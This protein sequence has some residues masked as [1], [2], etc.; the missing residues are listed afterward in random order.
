MSETETHERV[1]LYEDKNYFSNSAY[2]QSDLKTA[3]ESPWLMWVRKH[4]GLA[5]TKETPAMRSG[6]IDHMAILEPERFRQTYKLLDKPRTTKEGKQQAK[7]IA[8]AGLTPITLSQQIEADGMAQAIREHPW[9]SKILKDGHPEV[10][11][12]TKHH[13]TGLNLK[14]KLDWFD[15]E[16]IT[17]L[18]TVPV[19]GASKANFAHQVAKYKYQ[20]QAAHYLEISGASEFLFLVIE[21]EFPFQIGVYELDEEALAHGQLLRNKALETVAF[22]QSANSW[23]GYTPSAPETISLP[24]YAFYQ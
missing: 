23:P 13:A 19:G 16:R 14:G 8:D 4:N 24:T 15:G 21:R 9:A 2:S 6:T 12:Y 10:S 11:V 3:L 1:F 5:P 18:K 22:C 17:D 20:L 7:E